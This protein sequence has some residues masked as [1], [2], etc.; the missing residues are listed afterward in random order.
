MSNRYFKITNLSLRNKTTVFILTA[1]LTLFGIFSYKSM[2]KSLYPDIVMPT[3]LVQTVYPG[4]SPLLISS[5]T[6][7]L[8][9]LL[10]PL[11]PLLPPPS[12]PAPLPPLPSQSQGVH[13]VPLRGPLPGSRYAS[14]R[15]R[16]P[17]AVE[18][19]F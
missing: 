12:L 8:L 18:R 1:L 9:V 11:P 3:I 13:S 17:S 2:P 14:A 7:P 10:S 4:N 6:S 16:S 5:L 19:H 15:S